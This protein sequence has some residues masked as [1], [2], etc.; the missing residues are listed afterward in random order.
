MNWSL[1]VPAMDS[2]QQWN[3]QEIDDAWT[4]PISLDIDTKGFL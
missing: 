1:H 3:V 2:V 4:L